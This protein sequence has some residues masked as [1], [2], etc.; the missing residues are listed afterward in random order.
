MNLGHSTSAQTVLVGPTDDASSYHCLY[1]DLARHDM[2][3]TTVAAVLGMSLPNDD[4]LC[5]RT[6]AQEMTTAPM[7]DAPSGQTSPQTN[8]DW[9]YAVGALAGFTVGAIALVVVYVVLQRR[10][11]NETRYSL[12]IQDD[13]LDF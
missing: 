1:H 12:L 8:A 6:T 5:E 11:R 3:Y 2:R 4:H 13:E 9:Q 10:R 7:I